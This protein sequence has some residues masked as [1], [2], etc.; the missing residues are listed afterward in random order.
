VK[1]L[2]NDDD[3]FWKSRAPYQAGFDV[4]DDT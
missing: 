2:D 4:L 3:C 1:E